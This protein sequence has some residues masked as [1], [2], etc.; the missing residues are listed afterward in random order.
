MILLPVLLAAAPMIVV[1]TPPGPAT[2]GG[3]DCQVNRIIHAGDPEE[4]LIHPL[5]AEPEAQAL[6]AVDRE[7]GGCNKPVVLIPKVGKP[8]VR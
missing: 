2:N 1:A 6:Y 4:R 7:V 3:E 8:P 5:G